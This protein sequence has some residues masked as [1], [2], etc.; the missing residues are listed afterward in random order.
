MPKNPFSSDYRDQ[1][2]S[3]LISAAMTGSRAALEAL[4]KRHQ[5]YIYNIAHKLVLSPDDAQDITQEVLVI[6]ITKLGQFK[7]DSSFKTWLYRI[8]FNHFLKMKKYRLE[9]IITDF[10]A[11]TGLE[12]AEMHAEVEEAKLGC[13]SAML[14]C[15]D[16][17]QRLVF[18]LGEIFGVGH[19]LGAELLNLSKD[20]FRQRL[21]RARKDLY[22]FMNR[23]CGLVNTA[24]PC[25]CARKTKGF[26]K[27]NWVDPATMRFNTQYLHRMREVAEKSVAELENLTD[28]RYAELFRDHPFQEHDH[29]AQLFQNLLNDERIAATFHLCEPEAQSP[30]S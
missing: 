29:T 23:K 14:L 12:L 8:T 21:A 6:M 17:E 30:T 22:Q 2:D 28:A 24:N 1:P 18:V 20:N 13:M 11:L 19:A 5:H 16:R 26:I 7:G 4:V 3:E 25:R 15:L 9:E 27:A 10:D